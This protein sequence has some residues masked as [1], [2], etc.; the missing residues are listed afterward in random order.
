MDF[1]FDQVEDTDLVADIGHLVVDTA[2]VEGILAVGMVIADIDL[3]ADKRQVGTGL[4]VGTAGIADTD[5]E[6]IVRMVVELNFL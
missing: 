3:V 2:P 4:E 5:L 1:E 6:G